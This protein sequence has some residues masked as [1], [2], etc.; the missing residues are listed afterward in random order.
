MWYQKI[1]EYFEKRLWNLE[2]VKNAVAKG[3]I[4]ADEFEQITGEKYQ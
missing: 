4:T 1:K 3:K 2:M